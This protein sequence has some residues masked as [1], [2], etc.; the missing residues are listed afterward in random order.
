MDQQQDGSKAKEGNEMAHQPPDH[1]GESSTIPR[2]KLPPPP[3]PPLTS[4]R[5]LAI[6]DCSRPPPMKYRSYIESKPPKLSSSPFVVGDSTSSSSS[7][8][9]APIPEGTSDPEHTNLKCRMCLNEV[10]EEAMDKCSAC[11]AAGHSCC[12]SCLARFWEMRINS[13]GIKW[14][15]CIGSTTG[16]CGNRPSAEDIRRVAGERVYKRFILFMRKK[17]FADENVVFCA[18]DLCWEPIFLDSALAPAAQGDI[19]CRVAPEHYAKCQVCLSYT[20]QYCSSLIQTNEFAEDSYH[21]CKPYMD[22]P[23]R[24]RPAIKPQIAEKGFLARWFCGQT[25]H[26]EDRSSE[27]P[28]EMRIVAFYKTYGGVVVIK[29]CPLCKVLIERSDGCDSMQCAN[30]KF[31]FCWSCLKSRGDQY[32]STRIVNAKKA[33]GGLVRSLILSKQRNEPA[34]V[35]DNEKSEEDLLLLFATDRTIFPSVQTAV[36]IVRGIGACSCTFTAETPFR[37]T[38]RNVWQAM[39]DSLSNVGGILA[40]PFSKCYQAQ[41]DSN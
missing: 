29:H 35:C 28:E 13:N 3:P 20:C 16:S 7:S 1:D 10:T 6:T 5:F 25:D 31:A 4:N 21:T 26:E 34:P 36:D 14:L 33:I 8:S 9:D 27:D 40:S 37:T 11:P 22:A 18:N 17:L 2:R 38:V 15:T 19:A 23:E 41:A 39:S 32:E 30:C 12:R 24:A